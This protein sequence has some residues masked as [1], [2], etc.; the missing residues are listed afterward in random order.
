MCKSGRATERD[1]QFHC[2]TLTSL[3]AI[4]KVSR[5][6]VGRDRRFCSWGDAGKGDAERLKLIEAHSIISNDSATGDLV[7]IESDSCADEAGVNGTCLAESINEIQLIE[8]SG[9][10]KARSITSTFP[11]IS[12]KELKIRCSK[13]DQEFSQRLSLRPHLWA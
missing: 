12:W 1:R 7:T 10:A 9:G 6:L 3:A 11:E 2:S 5:Q 13:L 8:G 4:I